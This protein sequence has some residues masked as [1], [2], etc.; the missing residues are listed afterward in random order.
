MI[1]LFKI[2]FILYHVKCIIGETLLKPHKG[3]TF[4]DTCL[5]VC[6]KNSIREYKLFV[7]T[8]M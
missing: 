8:I 4:T 1:I 6:Y 2:Y 5:N 7:K 3:P